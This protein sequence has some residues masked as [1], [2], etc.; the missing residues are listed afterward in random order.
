MR[1]SWLLWQKTKFKTYLSVSTILFR[2]SFFFHWSSLNICRSS[3]LFKKEK[4]IYGKYAKME[5]K[6]K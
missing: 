4:Y 5:A 3:V 1:G 6:M 2:Y